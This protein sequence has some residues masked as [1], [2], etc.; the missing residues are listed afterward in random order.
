VERLLAT[1]GDLLARAVSRARGRQEPAA[2][3]PARYRPSR[4]GERASDIRGSDLSGAAVELSVADPVPDRRALLFLTS[5]CGA[6]IQ[7]WDCAAPVP[8]LTVVVPDRATES[9]RDLT[10]LAPSGLE[11]VLASSAW[12]DYEVPGAPWLVVVE[13]GLV[14]YECAPVSWDGVAEVLTAGRG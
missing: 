9:I 7:L 1:G 8:R 10:R 13:S 2:R 6:C 3:R 12:F 11:L 14:A 4:V 5:S